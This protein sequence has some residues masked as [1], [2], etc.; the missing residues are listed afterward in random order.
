MNLRLAFLVLAIGLETSPTAGR[1]QDH[2]AKVDAFLAAEM[3]KRN[4]PGLAVAIVREGRVVK[5]ASYGKA[6]L[7]LEVPVTERTVFQINSTTKSFSSVAVLMLV[8][9]GMLRLDDPIGDHLDSLPRSWRAVTI[10]QLLNHT[11]GLP[12][13]VDQANGGALLARNVGAAL[14]LLAEAPLLFKPASKWSYNQTNYMLLG[15]LIE[16]KSGMPFAQF[17]LEKEFKSLGITGAAFGDARVVVPN[18][19]TGYTKYSNVP[20][21]PTVLDRPQNVWYE[22]EPILYTAAAL[23]LSAKDFATWLA[24]LLGGKLISR[25][26]LEEI[27]KPT[28]LADGTTVHLGGPRGYGLG[29]PVVDRKKHRAAGGSGGARAGFFVYPDDDLAVIVLTNLSGAG[30]ESLVEGIAAIY[31]PGLDPIR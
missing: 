27:W 29:W 20:G 3:A 21:P 23:N 26:S 9:A 15:M 22:F 2:S 19:A 31:L 18:R 6:N 14:R 10:R 11:S 24:G 1:A 5:V 4:I 13:V 8:E 7:E 28:T 30:P 25:Q 17:C 12:D 16:K